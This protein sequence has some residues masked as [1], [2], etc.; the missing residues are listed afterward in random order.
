MVDPSELNEE[1][2][3]AA[4]RRFA[5]TCFNQAWELLD[6]EDRTHAD[7]LD[8]VRLTHTSHWH[9]LQVPD[10]TPTNLSIATWFTSR[11]YAE[12]GDGASAAVYAE[13]CQEISQPN[14]VPPFFVGYGFEAMARAEALLHNEAGMNA[15]LASAR[16]AAEQVEDETEKQALLADLSTIALSDAE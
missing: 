2:L 10:H 16:E 12:L 14:V 6:K 13:Q 15:A 7:E 11:V 4:H 8:L 5:A 1:T 3:V 9:W